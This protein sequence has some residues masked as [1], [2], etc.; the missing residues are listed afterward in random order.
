MAQH[1]LITSNMALNCMRDPQ[2]KKI[3]PEFLFLE[4]KLKQH[5]NASSGCSSCAK[6]RAQKA[7]GADFIRLLASM[8]DERVSVFKKFIGSE[9]IMINS[10][11]TKT[12]KFKTLIR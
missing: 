7:I 12:R 1:R 4:H 3:L 11:D 6:R 2:F 5:N 9:S 10:V 8:S